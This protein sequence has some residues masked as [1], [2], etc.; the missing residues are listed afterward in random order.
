M[1]F[2]QKSR[3]PNIIPRDL[4]LNVTKFSAYYNNQMYKVHPGKD[5]IFLYVAKTKVDLNQNL[6]DLSLATKIKHY[7]NCKKTLRGGKNL[8]SFCLGVAFA[9]PW[10]QACSDYENRG[11]LLTKFLPITNI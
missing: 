10:L 2:I 4:H 7:K 5:Y 9:T 1:T 3:A 6:G 11:Q 8:A